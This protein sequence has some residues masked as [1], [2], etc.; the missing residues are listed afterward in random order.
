[1]VIASEG[2]STGDA[3]AG[4]TSTTAN[5]SC[6]TDPSVCSNTC[7]NG[8]QDPDEQCDDGNDID[9]DGC[10]NACS[11]PKCGDTIVQSGEQCDDGNTINTDA[12]TNTC[13]AAACGDTFVQPDEQCDQGGLQTA[14]CEANCTTPTCGDGIPNTLVEPPEQCDNGTNDDPL[15]SPTLPGPNP[16]AVGCVAAEFCGDTIE[17]GPGPEPCDAGGVQTAGCEADC[18]VPVCGDGTVNTLAGEACDDGN[19][20]DGDGCSADCSA[21]ERRVFISSNQYGGDMDFALDN[22]DIL[23]GL[24]LADARCNALAASARLSGTFK[25]WLSDMTT[26]P[27]A[28]MDTTFSGVYRLG[29]DGFPVVATGWLDLVDGSL[30]LPIDVDESGTTIANFKNV[31]TNT[32][33]DGTRA[34]NLHCEG[35]TSTDGTTTVGTAAATNATWT[36]LV[37]GQLCSGTNRIYCFED[38]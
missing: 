31:W 19:Q 23:T 15:Y 9:D 4:T 22:P 29:S 1:M 21:I 11:L 12:C 35:W 6:E 3:T 32:L 28:R 7:G 33:P 2:S 37:P 20:I 25:A 13:N 16:C 27:A 36:N 34:S 14:A 26:E 10:T 18:R 24:A 8:V 17:N 38:P 5:T 30:A